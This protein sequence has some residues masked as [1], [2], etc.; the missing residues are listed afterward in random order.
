MK[1]LALFLAFLSVIFMS[2]STFASD[3]VNSSEYKR[4]SKCVVKVEIT[5]K[6][7]D[8]SN[9]KYCLRDWEE[10]GD[11][12]FYSRK[13]HVYRNISEESCFNETKDMLLG[14]KVDL[15]FMEQLMIVGID[16]IIH[17]CQGTVTRIRKIKYRAQR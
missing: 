10:D 17:K 13:K 4:S 9:Y 7:E 11:G 15:F 6:E 2:N 14:Q 3:E 12:Y 1:Q 8:N 16:P 5:V